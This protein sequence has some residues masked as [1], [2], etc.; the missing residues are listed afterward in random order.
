MKKVSRTALVPYSAEH[1]F[2]LVNDVAAYPSFLDWC[3]KTQVFEQTSSTMRAELTLGLLGQKVSFTTRNTLVRPESI[4]LQL[5]SGALKSLQ[6]QWRFKSLKAD[7]C[8]IQ[9]DVSFAINGLLMRPLEPVLEK[10]LD[11]LVDQ[12]VQRAKAVSR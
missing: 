5:E 3:V 7:A 8:K 4:E 9:L 11:G 10:V 12:F 1:M 2:D 6:G